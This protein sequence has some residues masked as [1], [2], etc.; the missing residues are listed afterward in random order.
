MSTPSIKVAARDAG[1]VIAGEPLAVDLADTIRMSFDPPRD[2]I[3]DVQRN[4]IF[5]KVEQPQLPEGAG[6][7]DLESTKRLRA[8]I[9]RLFDAKV[10]GAPL[11]ADAL[12]L[13]N[14][15][16]AAAI[17]QP[18]LSTTEERPVARVNWISETPGA[19]SLAVA[20][21]SAIEVLTGPNADRLRR[22]ASHACSM[23]FVALNA[24][25]QWCTPDG[26]GNRERVARYARAAVP[27]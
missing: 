2:L 27:I 23:F 6:A 22:C 11:D 13:I 3:Q 9:R 12:H 20:A 4:E 5:W 7:A 10:D 24:K 19:L 25:R 17:A 15:F 21:R 14:Q 1:L 18:Q 16:A 26:C 8:G